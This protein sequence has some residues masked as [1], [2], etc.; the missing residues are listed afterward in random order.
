MF[1]LMS[2]Q[3]VSIRWLEKSNPRQRAMSP[4]GRGDI[5]RGVEWGH[6]LLNGKPVFGSNDHENRSNYQPEI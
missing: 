6:R 4:T 2:I 3:I 5:K 1:I